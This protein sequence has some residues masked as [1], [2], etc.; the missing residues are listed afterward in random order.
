MSMSTG[1]AGDGAAR[2]RSNSDLR[3]RVGGRGIGVDQDGKMAPEG[4]RAATLPQ[5][6]IPGGEYI[7][8]ALPGMRIGF[9]GQWDGEGSEAQAPGGLGE[10][11]G[12]AALCAGVGRAS[13]VSRR[14]LASVA[15]KF[16][17]DE[18]S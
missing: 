5:V 8:R 6:R 2:F 9:G 12:R 15:A 1:G 13:V 11:R 10:R 14:Q 16:V 3:E 17:A 18:G 7:Q 4:G